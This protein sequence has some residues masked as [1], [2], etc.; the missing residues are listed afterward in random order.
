MRFEAYGSA[1]CGRC[2]SGLLGRLTGPDINA[3]FLLPDDLTS[4][5]VSDAVE[6]ADA[7]RFSVRRCDGARAAFVPFAC[8]LGLEG[9]SVAIAELGLSGNRPSALARLCCAITSLIAIL[10][11]P[12]RA[13]GAWAALRG[14]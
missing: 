4:D 6:A 13:D 9:E 2:S 12:G 7:T 5:G 3:L 1:V 10:L 14:M 8:A 11:P